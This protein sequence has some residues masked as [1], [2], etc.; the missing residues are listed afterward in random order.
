MCA[1]KYKSY[2][3]IFVLFIL[4]LSKSTLT[5]NEANKEERKYLLFDGILIW[6]KL[7]N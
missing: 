2:M 6:L 3:T 4:S 1:Y 7:V 5:P